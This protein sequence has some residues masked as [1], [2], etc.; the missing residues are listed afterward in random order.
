MIS[1]QPIGKDPEGGGR[2]VI[3]GARRTKPTIII[4]GHNGWALGAIRNLSQL[5]RQEV[6]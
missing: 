5:N 6:C 2:A 1:Q 4:L 3:R